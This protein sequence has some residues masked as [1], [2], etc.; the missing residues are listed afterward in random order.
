MFLPFW[1]SSVESSMMPP[2]LQLKDVWVRNA[3]IHDYFRLRDQDE[4]KL[5]TELRRWLT[6]DTK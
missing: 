1:T 3:G 2:S 4:L 6:V 5:Q